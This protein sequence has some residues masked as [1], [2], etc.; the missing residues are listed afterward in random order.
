M[1]KDKKEMAKQALKTIQE[2]EDVYKVE[3]RVKD[4]KILFNA[5]KQTFRVRKPTLEEQSDI[6]T[7]R[8][9][10]YLEL[11]KDD[12]FLFRDKWIEIYTKKGIDIKKMEQDIKRLEGEI[13]T[14]MLDL[15]ITKDAKGIGIL[16]DKILNL[17][18][19]QAGISIERTDLL[20]DSIEDQIHIF[21]KSYAAYKVLERKEEDKWIR[22]FKTF[23]EFQK[24]EDQN[25]IAQLFY[26]FDCLMYNI[27]VE[28]K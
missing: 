2:I 14:A 4:N 23:D 5:G 1:D 3:N 20:S 10:K 26:N 9:K 16:K 21:T 28:N 18:D 7:A 25:L 8:R 22:H 17:R 19:E 11:I 24:S 6:D 15:A 12:S 27:E 13:K